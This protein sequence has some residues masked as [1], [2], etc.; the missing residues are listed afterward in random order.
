MLSV[1]DLSKKLAAASRTEARELVSSCSN[2]T[3]PG[4]KKEPQV[5]WPF[6][7]ERTARTTLAPVAATALAVSIPIPEEHPVTRMT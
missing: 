4:S 6:S 3:R 1:D 7:R 5:S 2:S